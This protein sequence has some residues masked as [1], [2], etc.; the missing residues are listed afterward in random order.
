M[1]LKPHRG[2]AAS[3][4]T[5]LS[6]RPGL[7]RGGGGDR[8]QGERPLGMHQCREAPAGNHTSHRDNQ[9]KHQETTRGDTDGETG[10]DKSTC[11]MPGQG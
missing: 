9:T 8:P 6:T 3:A 7:Q 1:C 11:L 4:Q 5:P 10:P 2:Q